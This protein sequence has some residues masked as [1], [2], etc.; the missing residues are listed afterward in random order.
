MAHIG[1]P[2]MKRSPF[3]VLFGY[4]PPLLPAMGEDTIVATM[5]A[6]LEKR[7]CV[8]QQLK[9]ELTMA[10]NHVK[11]YADRRRSEREFVVGEKVY[12]KVRPAHLKKLAHGQITKLSP[13][14]LWTLPN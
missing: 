3:E 5:E 6:Y 13:Q 9:E 14:V 10:Q 7:Q 12:L 11:Q 4:Q 2:S 1:F 8:L